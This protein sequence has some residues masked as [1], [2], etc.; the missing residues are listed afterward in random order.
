MKLHTVPAG[1]GAL[2]VRQGF[3]VF[4]RRPLAFC[5]LFVSFVIVM[6]LAAL[7]Y[8]IGTVLVCGAMPLASLG[9]MIATRAALAGRFPTPAAFIE[10]LRGGRARLW[11]QLQLAGLYAMGMLAI[12][13]IFWSVGGAEF[14][15]LQKLMAGGKASPE[16][17]IP[18]ISNGRLQTAMWL[19][20]ALAALLS[21]PFWHA[22]ALAHWD[23]QGLAQSLFSST[24]ACWRNK[25]AFTIYGLTWVG[26]F[27]ALVTAAEVIFGV[28][29][30]PQLILY[31]I[32]PLWLLF[33]TVFYASLYFTFA[34]SFEPSAPDA[35]SLTP[36]SSA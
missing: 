15:A 9:F 36:G 34:D 23:G 33:A 30:A 8:P 24:I 3:L 17:L 21:V 13:W 28:I 10:P 27:L 31:L 16:S 19:L 4:C 26:V 6:Q 5:G 35:E 14:E 2:W 29:G 12:G 7:L 22:P 11:V 32:P 1:R 20:S 18:L 25:A